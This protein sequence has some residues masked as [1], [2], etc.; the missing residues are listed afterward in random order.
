MAYGYLERAWTY[1]EYVKEY[2][3]LQAKNDQL[4]EACND[5]YH[6][7]QTA[8]EAAGEVEIGIGTGLTIVSAKEKYHKIIKK[9][10]NKP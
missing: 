10:Q 5:L 7:L 9:S 8:L 4:V 1:A 3:Q 6:A 2:E